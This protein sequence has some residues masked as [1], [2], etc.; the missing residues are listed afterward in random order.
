M[1]LLYPNCTMYYICL[2]DVDHRDK[3]KRSSLYR[4][5]WGNKWD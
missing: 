2:M 4:S 1:Y 5:I 3:R